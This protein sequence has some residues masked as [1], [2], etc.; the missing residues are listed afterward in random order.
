MPTCPCAGPLCWR[1]G[2]SL[3]GAGFT[4]AHGAAVL[5]LPGCRVGGLAL[6][7]RPSAPCGPWLC[8]WSSARPGLSDVGP[9]GGCPACGPFPPGRPPGRLAARAL[10]PLGVQGGLGV[11][12]GLAKCV[13]AVTGGAWPFTGRGHILDCAARQGVADPTLA[14]LALRRPPPRTF[15]ACAFPSFVVKVS[16]CGILALPHPQVGPSD[17]CPPL[18]SYLDAPAL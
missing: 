5:T 9:V 8:S 6:G 4:R 18:I 2:P 13:H 10:A 7:P 11:G 3:A 17:L 14:A 12:G 16:C 1:A 15:I